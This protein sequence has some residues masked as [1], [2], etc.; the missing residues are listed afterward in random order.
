VRIRGVESDVDIVLQCASVYCY[1]LEQLSEDQK[2]Y[3]QRTHTGAE[4]NCDKLKAELGGWRSKKF[5]Q[6][7]EPGEKAMRI[8]EQ[9]RVILAAFLKTRPISMRP[10]L[11]ER[12]FRIPAWT[13]GDTAC[14]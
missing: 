13:L 8:T 3:Y 1:D 9:T 11:S 7:Y 5:P 2:A 4:Y 14:Y 10:R 12:A 6:D